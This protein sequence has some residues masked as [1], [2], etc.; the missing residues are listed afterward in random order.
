[1]SIPAKLLPDISFRHRRRAYRG[2][3]PQRTH[4]QSSRAFPRPPSESLQRTK[5]LDRHR[6]PRSRHAISSENRSVRN[7]RLAGLR[8]RSANFD[9]FNVEWAKNLKGVQVSPSL[10]DMA[11]PLRALTHSRRSFTVTVTPPMKLSVVMPVYN[12]QATLREV[13]ARVLAVA[14]RDRTD[15]RRRRLDRRLPRNPDGIA[16]QSSRKSRS[17][18]SPRIWAKAPRFAAAFKRRLET[19]S[20]F[21]TPTSNTI[22]PTTPFCCAR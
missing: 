16:D 8:L 5:G 7:G 12:E 14:A 10:R 9:F 3:H 18:F 1:M 15:L 20:S 17:C 4:D 19:S 11:V 2:P 21:R 6:H 13:I 22:L